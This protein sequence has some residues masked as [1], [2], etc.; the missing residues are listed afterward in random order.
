[1][2]T[3]AAYSAN[4]KEAATSI[5]LQRGVK[6]A[7]AETGVNLNS[8]RSWVTRRQHGLPLN[9]TPKVHPRHPANERPVRPELP[10]GVT[11]VDEQGRIRTP[12]SLFLSVG[13][14]KGWFY[15]DRADA[16][17]V[18]RKRGTYTYR[19]IPVAMWALI[20]RV[21]VGQGEPPWREI[22]GIVPRASAD[23]EVMPEECFHESTLPCVGPNGCTGHLIEDLAIKK[24]TP[25]VSA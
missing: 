9:S 25:E 17:N 22:V 1:M 8:L 4:E 15:E 20:E 7:A 2:T 6:V 13:S 12:R 24:K 5:A 11:T 3:R 10:E 23:Q 16:V 14:S 18:K 21:N 19:H